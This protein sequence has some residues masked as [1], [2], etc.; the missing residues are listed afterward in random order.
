[1]ARK[2]SHFGSNNQPSPAG[3]ASASLASIGSIG[4]SIGK[5]CSALAPV[6][7]WREPTTLCLRRWLDG[8]RRWLPLLL[9]RARSEPRQA[10][11][12]ERHEVGEAPIGLGTAA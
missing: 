9:L 10:P 8:G 7:V 3:S 11:E 1:M 4:G 5:L 2:P 6:I 12:G